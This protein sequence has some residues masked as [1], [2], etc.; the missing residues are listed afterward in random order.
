MKRWIIKK[1]LATRCYMCGFSDG[2]GGGGG[3]CGF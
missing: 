1:I 3:G 2:E